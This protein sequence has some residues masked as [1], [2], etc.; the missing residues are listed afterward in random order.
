[1]AVVPVLKELTLWVEYRGGSFEYQ[2]AAF[3]GC[4]LAH[5]PKPS[6]QLFIYCLAS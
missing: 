3:P 4:P 5:L 6:L 2:S 1:L